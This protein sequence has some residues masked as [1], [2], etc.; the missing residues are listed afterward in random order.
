MQLIAHHQLPDAHPD[1]E[2]WQ[3]SPGQLPSPV[4]LSCMPPHGMK[5]AFGQS[6]S[7]VLLLSSPSSLCTPKYLTGRIAQEAEKS[8]ALCEP[9]SATLKLQCV[10]STALILN[11]KH[12]TIPVNRK[13]ISSIPAETRTVAIKKEKR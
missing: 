8:L 11:T 3:P 12:S 2:Q 9:C 6:G 4:L 1:P 10:I 7:L 13:K 5:P